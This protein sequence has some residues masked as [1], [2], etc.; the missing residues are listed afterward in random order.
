[1][2][3]QS[4]LHLIQYKITDGYSFDW[5]CFGRNAHGIQCDEK[6]GYNLVAIYDRFTHRVYQIEAWDYITNHS[7][8]WTDPDFLESHVNECAANNVDY[9]EACDGVFIDFQMEDD[10]INMG[11][12]IIEAHNA[13][14]LELAS[15]IDEDGKEEIVLNLSEQE[16]FDLMKMAHEQDMSLNEFV[17]SILVKFIESVEKK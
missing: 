3:L 14:I 4:F 11:N 12:K 17:E 8:R 10:I 1:M 15:D 6:D 13:R 5:K 7:Y 9:Y 2:Q 16:Q